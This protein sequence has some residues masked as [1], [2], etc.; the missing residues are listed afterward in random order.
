LI[1]LLLAI[2]LACAS[3]HDAPSGWAYPPQCCGEV[4]CH[5]VGC[6]ELIEGKSG[7]WSYGKVRFAASQISPSE[8]GACHVCINPNSNAPLCAFIITSW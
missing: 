8:D 2:L 7:S 4:D 5:P 6:D 1:A 3:A